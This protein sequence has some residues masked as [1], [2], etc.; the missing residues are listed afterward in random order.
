MEQAHHGQ[1]A[2]YYLTNNGIRAEVSVNAIT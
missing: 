2:R 1:H